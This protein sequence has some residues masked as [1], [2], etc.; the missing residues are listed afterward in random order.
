MKAGAVATLRWEVNGAVKVSID[1]D[2]GVVEPSGTLNVQPRATTVYKLEATGPGGQKTT[3]E[4]SV[5]VADGAS[6]ATLYSE[7]VAERRA[8][9][10]ARALALFRQAAEM[11]DTRAMLEL[12]NM[13]ADGEGGEKNYAEATRWFRMAADRGSSASMLLL[14]GMYY[15]GK[16][17]PQDFTS[18]AYWF[19]KAADSGEPD[20]KYDL[21]MM[22]E[23]G[24]GVARD[25]DKAK[26][27]YQGAAKL[28]NEEA[29]K[30]VADLGGN[31]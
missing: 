4:T 3:G 9:R 8:G 28:G 30:R 31:R 2:A 10:P 19:G 11:G 12:G 15:L 29:R 17:V 21:G 13:S 7:A 22:Y 18:A 26:Q 1:P 24:L 16:G 20:A 14:G 6:A 23:R 25:M 27:L 5:T